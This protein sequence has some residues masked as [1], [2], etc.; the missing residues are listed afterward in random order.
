[1]KKILILILVPLLLICG[2]SKKTY[3]EISYDDF[4]QKIDN[5]ESFI[6]FIGAE[7]CAHCATYK[8]TL[9]SVINKYNVDVYYID[10][11]KLSSKESSYLNNAVPFTGTPTTVFIKNGKEEST[12]NRIVGDMDF[13]YIVEKFKKNGY[14]EVE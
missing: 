4:K 5:K 1:M 7:S 11:D 13:E 12:Y 14:I 2:C 9:N 3:T 6:L 8:P 10:I